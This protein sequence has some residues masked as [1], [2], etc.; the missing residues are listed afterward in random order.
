MSKATHAILKHSSTI[1]K[2]KTLAQLKNPI[3]KIVDLGDIPG[4]SIIMTYLL[5]LITLNPSKTRYHQLLL[6]RYNHF[7][8]VWVA[9]NF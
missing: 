6:P 2:L 3:I 4:V 8:I 5:G 9:N 1:K 7:L